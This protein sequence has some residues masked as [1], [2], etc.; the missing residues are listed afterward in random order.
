ML[1]VSPR[2]PNEKYRNT[3]VEELLLFPV[4]RLL[5]RKALCCL[6]EFGGR[7]IAK[8]VTDMWPFCELNIT[9]EPICVMEQ[10]ASAGRT[11]K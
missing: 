9:R 8:E 5:V 3:N 4:N 10:V 6:P 2:S 11:L 7:L 1:R